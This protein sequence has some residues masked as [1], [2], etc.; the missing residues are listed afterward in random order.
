MKTAISIPDAVY[1]AAEMVAR[2]LNISRSDFYT[3]A[4]R[5]YVSKHQKSH[6]T[7][8]LNSL[9]SQEESSLDPALLDSQNISV[10]N[11]SW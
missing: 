2:K 7:E 8:I 4:V 3:K 1:H 10:G 11:E 5:E 6:I 9:Y